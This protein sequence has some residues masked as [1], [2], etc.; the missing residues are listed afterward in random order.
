MPRVLNAEV[1]THSDLAPMLWHLGMDLTLTVLLGRG[2]IM[3]TRHCT[4]GFYIV[5]PRTACRPAERSIVLC[6]FCLLF[7][8]CT[9][10]E[11]SGF[12]WWHFLEEKSLAPGSQYW[13]PSS[14]W[15][16]SST[17]RGLLHWSTCSFYLLATR[18]IKVVGEVFLSH[19]FVVMR[20]KKAGGN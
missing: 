13:L 15:G 10:Q 3:E 11:L 7:S 19:P 4:L 16:Q 12:C 8:L 2:S 9:D 20:N 18:K 6:A 5:L 14:G 17:H 1:Y